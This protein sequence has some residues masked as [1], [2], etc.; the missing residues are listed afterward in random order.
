MRAGEHRAAGFVRLRR[1]LAEHWAVLR[2]QEKNVFVGLLLKATG[3]GPYA[4]EVRA[5]YRDLA[6]AFNI[7][8]LETLVGAVKSLE[9]RGW[10]EVERSTNRHE[11]TVF[12]IAKFDATANQTGTVNRSEKGNSTVNGNGNSRGNG[13]SSEQ[14][15]LKEIDAPN[16][17]ETLETE[18]TYASAWV[19]RFDEWWSNWPRKLSKSD[20]RK[21]YAKVIV[22]GKVDAD[23]R[24]ELKPFP[25]FADRHEQL[26]VATK[27]WLPDFDSRPA[28]RVPYGATF[29]RRL[30]WLTPPEQTS[31]RQQSAG[32][33]RDRMRSIPSSP[34]AWESAAQ[35]EDRLR[36]EAA[37]S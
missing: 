29:I 19:S 28:D 18:D 21:A 36:R 1:G 25:A 31:G 33:L 11:K 7:S 9:Q 20:A 24:A 17:L 16:T 22:K 5:S 30:D 37:A 13:N 26:V 6:A 3:T 14:L 8:K 27:L 2:P 12:R 32:H 10:I 34:M 4:G 23:Q 35:Y 15:N